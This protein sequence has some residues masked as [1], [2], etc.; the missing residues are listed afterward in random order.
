MKGA[1]GEDG[2][3]VVQDKSVIFITFAAFISDKLF[4]FFIVINWQKVCKVKQAPD[5]VGEL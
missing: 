5:S 1:P 4:F 2:C 3:S